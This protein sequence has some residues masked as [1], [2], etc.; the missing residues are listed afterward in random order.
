MGVSRGQGRGGCVA[1]GRN[2]EADGL[3]PSG[4]GEL[5]LGELVVRGREA[6]LES[7][8]FAGPAFAFGL[9]DAG[10]EVVADILQPVFLGGVSPEE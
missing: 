7:F 3:G 2:A 10:Q 8:G 1:V 4:E 5:D 9:G 6:D